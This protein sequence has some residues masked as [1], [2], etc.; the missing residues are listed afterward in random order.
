MIILVEWDG[1][2]DTAKIVKLIC[3]FE[4]NTGNIMNHAFAGRQGDIIF[5]TFALPLCSANAPQGLNQST[6]K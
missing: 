6:T 5:G 2:S 3:E 4:P 1:K